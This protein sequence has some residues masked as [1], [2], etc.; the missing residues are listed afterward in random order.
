MQDA[1]ANVRDA[2]NRGLNPGPRLF[3]ATKDLASIASYEPRTENSL[4]GTML[5]AGCDAADG[6][7]EVRKAVRRRIGAGADVVKFFPD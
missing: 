6:V 1:D 7:H 5:P 3:V 4:S 2:I